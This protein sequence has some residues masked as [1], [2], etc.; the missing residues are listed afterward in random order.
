M[1][2]RKIVSPKKNLKRSLYRFSPFFAQSIFSQTITNKVFFDVQIEG[3]ESG[4]IVLGL[5]GE[6]VPKTVENF[7]SL[8]RLLQFLLPPYLTHCALFLS[9]S[10]RFAPVKKGLDSPESLFTTRVASS[11]ASVSS[12]GRIF[13]PFLRQRKHGITH[14]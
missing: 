3:G 12:N 4:R 1:R 5:F 2:Q 14:K 9:F 7:V 13:A 8:S 11:I 10:A 6:A